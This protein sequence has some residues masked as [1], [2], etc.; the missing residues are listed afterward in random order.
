[1]E[2]L[3]LNFESLLSMCALKWLD[4]KTYCH[5]E[6]LAQLL[7]SFFPCCNSSWNAWS[8]GVSSGL[9][10]EKYLKQECIGLLLSSCPQ[11]WPACHSMSDTLVKFSNKLQ[12]QTDK[13]TEKG[14]YFGQHGTGRK[15]SNIRWKTTTC[16]SKM[17][18]TQIPVCQNMVV[19]R[20]SQ[21]IDK[22]S[23]YE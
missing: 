12:Q 4:C 13:F 22:K 5:R 11:V 1:M 15:N 2:L 23:P 17:M 8:S 20:P 10:K 9:I 18:H 3:K 19:G 21:R 14:F 6:A 7:F 16:S